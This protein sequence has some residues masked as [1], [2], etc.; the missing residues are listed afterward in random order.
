MDFHLYLF[1]HLFDSNERC[2]ARLIYHF[3]SYATFGR[4]GV[5][6]G[7]GG[8]GSKKVTG[9]KQILLLVIVIVDLTM[10]I[11]NDANRKKRFL[12]IK[13]SNS[14]I[15]FITRHIEKLP[16]YIYAGLPRKLQSIQKKPVNGLGL[17]KLKNDT[18][19]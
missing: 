2:V 13:F 1:I 17:R 15:L 10:V 3:A 9:S 16:Y 11:V 7:G 19:V 6:G 8:G 14:P 18:S 5:R 4:V 12:E